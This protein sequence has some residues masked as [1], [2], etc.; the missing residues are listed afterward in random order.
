MAAYYWDPTGGND[1]NSG[2]TAALPKLT[3]NGVAGVL[4]IGPGLNPGDEVRILRAAATSLVAGTGDHDFVNES[5]NIT[6]PADYPGSVGG[7]LLLAPDGRLYFVRDMPAATTV[8][9]ETPYKGGNTT[10]AG[11]RFIDVTTL[12]DVTTSAD[13]LISGLTIDASAGAPITFSGGWWDNA[14][15]S[16]QEEYFSN[17]APSVL[18]ISNALWISTSVIKNVIF[19]DLCF[20]GTGGAVNVWESDASGGGDAAEDI[21]VQRCPFYANPGNRSFFLG[22]GERMSFINSPVVHAKTG[23][24]TA[25]VATPPYSPFNTISFDHIRAGQSTKIMAYNDTGNISAGISLTMTNCD[26]YDDTT[27]VVSPSSFLFNI[28][29][30]GAIFGLYVSDC[31]VQGNDTGGALF[32][33]H[34]IG[35]YGG[36]ANYINGYVHK[37]ALSSFNYFVVVGVADRFS[38]GDISIDVDAGT[39]VFVVANANDCDLPV[40]YRN[41]QIAQNGGV[42]DGVA[43]YGV[44]QHLFVDSDFGPAG[45]VLFSPTL[46]VPEYGT[47]GAGIL[48]TAVDNGGVPDQQTA[49]V[50]A[51]AIDGASID[52]YS[53]GTIYADSGVQVTGLSA[54]WVAPGDVVAQIVGTYRYTFKMRAGIRTV[55]FHL[56]KNAAFDHTGG[57]QLPTCKLRYRQWAS[58]NIAE[59]EA[60]AALLAGESD[61]WVAKTINV[62][63]DHDQVVTMEWSG[64][65]MSGTGIMW[66]DNIA[67]S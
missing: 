38:M 3:L 1:A 47:M 32:F 23:Y 6:V 53:V 52:T 65:D 15:S 66:I 58:G 33:V 36:A 2:L 19:E 57:G 46:T 42:G 7:D 64:L 43:W 21:I 56:R 27:L 24:F 13:N 44:G 17:V 67:S 26:V 31:T 45:L 37:D 20:I 30:D 60:S 63:L 61:L 9:L 8:R 48:R 59:A 39:G 22:N 14:G 12:H 10:E 35:V 11:L 55:G 49:Y 50:G 40:L 34:G 16:E 18:D 29:C 4:S 54:K 28:Q 41:V 5:V 62:T 51:V 25:S